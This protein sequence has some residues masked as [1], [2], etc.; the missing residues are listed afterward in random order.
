MVA[1]ERFVVGIMFQTAAPVITS[2]L[3]ESYQITIE[4][5]GET[6]VVTRTKI[7]GYYNPACDSGDISENEWAKAYNGLVSTS[8]AGKKQADGMKLIYN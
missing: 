7:E 1:I 6:Y 5:N 2:A 3:G 8:V 4:Y